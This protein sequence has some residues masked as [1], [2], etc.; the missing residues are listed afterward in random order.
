MLG[1]QVKLHRKTFR[2]QISSHFDLLPQESVVADY[3]SNM[4]NNLGVSS[5]YMD[6]YNDAKNKIFFQNIRHFSM[7]EQ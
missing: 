4:G 5:A 3:F 6:T 1:N 7:T 2:P